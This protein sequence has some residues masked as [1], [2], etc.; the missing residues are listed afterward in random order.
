VRFTGE[1]D[2]ARLVDELR[3]C[4][5]IVLP[6]RAEGYGLTL[7]EAMATSRP[8]IAADIPTYREI[9]RDTDVVL[10]DFSDPAA[11]EASIRAARSSRSTTRSVARARERSWTAQA[12]RFAAVYADAL[13]HR[14]SVGA[15]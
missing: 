2:D 12:P 6:S 14:A 1:I 8:V 7:V 9:A 15:S 13:A 5:A 3:R 11:V 4:T 10:A